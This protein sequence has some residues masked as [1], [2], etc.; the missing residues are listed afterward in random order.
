MTVSQPEYPTKGRMYLFSA[1]LPEVEPQRH[2]VHAIHLHLH[3]L[4]AFL[5]QRLHPFPP[6]AEEVI[7]YYTII[8]WIGVLGENSDTRNNI[9]SR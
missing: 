5:Y 9:L 2:L 7:A 8:A 6:S 4:V 3:F 1:Q